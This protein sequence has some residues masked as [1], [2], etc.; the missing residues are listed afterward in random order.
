MKILVTGGAGFIGSNFVNGLLAKSETWEEIIVL[1]ALTYAGNLA[2]LK[3]ALADT[4]V[5]FIH[6]DI[7]DVALVNNLM[8]SIHT[9][10]HFAA[11]SH[12]DRSILNPNEFISTNVLGTNT[13]LNAALINKVS[14][15][16]HVSTDEVYGSIEVGSWT[17][18]SPIAPNSPYS[19]SKASS[20]LVALSYF[21]TFGLPVIVTR[22][23]NNYGKYQFPEKLI[24]LAISHLIDNI[25]I[26]IYGDG[27]N[28]RDWLDVRDHCRAI[29]LI[30]ENGIVG[31]VYNIGGGR[32]LSNIEM[33][34]LLLNE[35]GLDDT[36]INFVDD[37]KGHDRRYS[38]NYEK[39][40]KVCGFKTEHNF[41]ES[42]KETVD[43]YRSNE[44][45]WRP[46]KSQSR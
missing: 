23:S 3:P 43:W 19:A 6:G 44:A 42:L 20:D 33:V 9:V 34:K 25:P 46:L 7:R 5:R 30:I 4:R 10:V 24:P 13:L 37:R 45:W 26:P 35:F 36:Y 22:C 17:E 11:E 8:S 39:I 18:H 38:V 14:K 1:D 41:E 40:Q 28:S 15:F 27:L 16:I 29:N 32:E 12:V 31:E 21:R 2:N